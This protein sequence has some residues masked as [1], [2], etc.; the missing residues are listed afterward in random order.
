MFLNDVTTAMFRNHNSM[1]QTEKPKKKE[2]HM[3]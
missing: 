2:K 1:P 3:K